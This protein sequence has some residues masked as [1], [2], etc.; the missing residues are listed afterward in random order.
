MLVDREDKPG[1]VEMSHE[2]GVVRDRVWCC[3]G[4]RV[5]APGERE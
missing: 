5:H 2:P 4:V 1:L 3:A